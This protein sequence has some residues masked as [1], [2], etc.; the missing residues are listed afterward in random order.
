VVQI[1]WCRG[2]G[3]IKRLWGG[4]GT[5]FQGHFWILK[6][7]PKN[8]FPGNGGK[9]NFPF[10][11]YRNCTF[12]TKLFWKTSKFPNKKGTF[13]FNLLFTATL[14]CTKLQRHYSDISLWSF[15]KIWEVRAPAPPPPGSYAPAVVSSNEVNVLRYCMY[16]STIFEKSACNK[17]NFFW[18]TFGDLYFHSLLSNFCLIYVIYSGFILI[19]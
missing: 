14:A 15:E 7:A 3:S 6:R 16:L 1:Q 12:L 2:V 8:I 18:S 11:P 17:V 4:G 10:I 9:E 19:L 13:D 5:G